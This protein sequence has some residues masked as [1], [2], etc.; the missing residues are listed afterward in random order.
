MLREILVNSSILIL[1]LTEV[2]LAEANPVQTSFSNQF[3]DVYSLKN[4]SRKTNFE[5][6]LLQQKKII[7]RQT[8]KKLVM[9][10]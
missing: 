5:P 10:L 3:P 1:S 9:I 8:R 2:E 7:L 6:K 4:S